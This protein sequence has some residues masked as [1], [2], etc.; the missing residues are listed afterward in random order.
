MHKDSTGHIGFQ[1]KEGK[2][3]ALV[4]DSSAARNGVLTD[5]QILEINGKVIKV[6]YC[7]YHFNWLFFFFVYLWQNVVGLKDK[8]IVTEI[9]MSPNVVT[10]TVIPSYIYDH[11]VKK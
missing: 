1:F 9:G 7:C 11:M 5:H 3:I 2:I 4:K 6:N 8:D 10:I